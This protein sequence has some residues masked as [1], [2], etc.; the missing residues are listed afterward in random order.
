MLVEL[1]IMEQ[2]DH[3]V[4]EVVSGALADHSHRPRYQ[5]RQLNAEVEV[6]T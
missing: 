2:R 4:M 3:L 5:H 6:F 1:S